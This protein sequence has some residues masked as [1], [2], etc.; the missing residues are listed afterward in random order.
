MKEPVVLLSGDRAEAAKWV[1]YEKKHFWDLCRTRVRK[2]VLTPTNTVTV[3]V[4]CLPT[5][6]R[7]IIDVA[8]YS[9]PLFVGL[10]WDDVNMSGWGAPFTDKNY[11]YGTEYS[12][13]LREVL[14]PVSPAINRA[15]RAPEYHKARSNLKPNEPILYGNMEWVSYDNRVISWDGIGIRGLVDIPDSYSWGY[16]HYKRCQEYRDY[17]DFSLD[18]NWAQTPCGFRMLNGRI[19]T[20]GTE[21]V[22]PG[23]IYTRSEKDGYGFSLGRP[24]FSENIYYNGRVLAKVPSTWVVM[25]AAIQ[26]LNNKDYVVA[27]IGKIGKRGIYKEEFWY[28]PLDEPTRY[29]TIPFREYNIEDPSS[30]YV[31]PNKPELMLNYHFWSFSKDGNTAV[32]IREDYIKVDITTVAYDMSI[33]TG[34]STF[35]NPYVLKADVSNISVGEQYKIADPFKERPFVTE[36]SNNYYKFE[37]TNTDYANYTK[38][39]SSEWG[40]E[41]LRKGGRTYIAAD[42]IDNEI[43]TAFLD[44]GHIKEVEKGYRIATSVGLSSGECVRAESTLDLSVITDLEYG[45]PRITFSRYGEISDIPTHNN[46]YALKTYSDRPDDMNTEARGSS[47]NYNIYINNIDARY[48]VLVLSVARNVTTLTRRS[49]DYSL[50]DTYPLGKNVYATPEKYTENREEQVY[51]FGKLVES[52]PH[53]QKFEG[54]SATAVLLGDVRA[55][56]CGGLYTSEMVEFHNTIMPA[57]SFVASTGFP[58]EV[59]AVE[60]LGKVFILV[61][62]SLWTETDSKLYECSK[63]GRIVRIHNTS[64]YLGIGEFRKT[65]IFTDKRNASFGQYTV[66]G[67]I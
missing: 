27:V 11:P 7:I 21:N 60:A 13:S 25:G 37:A 22:G 57:P 30:E 26:Q 42:F 48:G 3:I 23:Y 28:A 19:C 34:S 55:S 49:Y 54:I 61:S 20:P 6:K 24:M 41:Y 4:E 16:R 29:K 31:G 40:F 50:I 5:L 39:I 59:K 12:D 66:A 52:I 58:T 51:V 46:V 18:I 64:K 56:Y 67:L 14:V 62:P 47:S 38:D 15:Y 9:G 63:D 45:A 43:V 8:Q 65:S 32:S 35:R 36:V 44:Y 53:R 1:E 17:E 10:P 33:Y 2:K